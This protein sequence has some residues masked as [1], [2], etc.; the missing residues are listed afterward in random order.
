MRSCGVTASRHCPFHYYAVFSLDK[1]FS[2][3]PRT[4]SVLYPVSQK[5]KPRLLVDFHQI[6]NMPV[7][8]PNKANKNPP[9]FSHEFVIQNHADIV[10]CLAMVF[11][12][13]LMI[14]VRFLFNLICQNKK[15]AGRILPVPPP[16]LLKLHARHHQ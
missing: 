8:R 13:G 2:V 5:E 12:I 7:R 4:L 11:V 6:A 14:Q 10:S 3:S 15:N 16:A 1:P 9:I